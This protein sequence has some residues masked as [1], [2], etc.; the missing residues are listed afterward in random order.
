MAQQLFFGGN[1]LPGAVA[2]YGATCSKNSV[3]GDDDGDG[4]A[5]YC[6]ADCPWCAPKARFLTQ[7]VVG[8][9]FPEGNSGELAPDRLLES[10]S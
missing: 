5:A 6:S 7:L 8:E 10:C 9:L 2:G 1:S 4:V 3:A